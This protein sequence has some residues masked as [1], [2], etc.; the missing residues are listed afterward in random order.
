MGTIGE[1]NRLELKLR[2][3]SAENLAY[4]ALIT[5]ALEFQMVGNFYPSDEAYLGQARKLRNIAG[6]MRDLADRVDSNA[7]RHESRGTREPL[8]EGKK[9]ELLARFLR[10]MTDRE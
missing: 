1:G 10:Q 6:L 9:D 8:P 7:A 2:F 3:E 5:E 4:I